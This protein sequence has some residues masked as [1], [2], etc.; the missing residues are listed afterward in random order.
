MYSLEFKIGGSGKVSDKQ[1]IQSKK[2]KKKP[3]GYQGANKR[4]FEK[5]KRVI[6]V[7]EETRTK[8]RHV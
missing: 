4:N 7:R 6:K 8:K 1:W 2:K 5:T 3:S